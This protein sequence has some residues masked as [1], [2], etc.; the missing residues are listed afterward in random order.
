MPGMAHAG[1]KRATS[2]NFLVYSNGSEEGLRKFAAKVEAFDSL[3]RLVTRLE[4]PPAPKRLEIYLLRD[5]ASI[6]RILGRAG[7][8]VSGIYLPN[9]SGALAL[10]PRSE[11][12]D[13]YDLDGETVLFH[14]YAHHFMMQYFA[15]A[16]PPWY[17]EG[18]AEYYSTAEVDSDKGTASIGKPAYHRAYGLNLSAPFPIKRLLSD[19]PNPRNGQEGDAY[20]GRAWLLTHMLSFSPP[21]KGQLTKYIDAYANGVPAEK[22]ATDAF[23]PISG[24]E[25]DL[26]R[27]LVARKMAYRQLSGLSIKGASIMIQAVSPA[28]DALIPERLNLMTGIEE[29]EADG[30]ISKVRREAALYPDSPY[31]WDLLAETEKL[32]D[33]EKGVAAAD[34]RLLQIKPDHI[35]ALLRKAAALADASGEAEDEQAHWKAVRALIVKANRADNDNTVALFRYYQSY[36]DQG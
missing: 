19:D 30:F 17:V 20:Y 13:K 23:G 34:E 31:A 3:L 35:P 12:S 36:R 26:K 16:Y 9:M 14:E 21:R 18:F 24:L 10:V 11:G 29:K 7:R 2:D 28:E 25:E 15:N 6:H 8:N 22:A 33:N 27:Y 4:A 5:Q 32:T 1:W